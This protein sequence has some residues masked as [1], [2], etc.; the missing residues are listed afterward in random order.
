VEEARGGNC[1]RPEIASNRRPATRRKGPFV[2]DVSIRPTPSRHSTYLVHLKGKERGILG[3]GD[4]ALFQGGQ[5]FAGRM[6]R[7][8]YFGK[9]V[10]NLPLDWG[11]RVLLEERQELYQ[12]G[13]KKKE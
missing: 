13:E 10:R 8:T 1:A 6:A 5:Q 3:V 12:R 9:E 2:E 11:K 7:D 4:L